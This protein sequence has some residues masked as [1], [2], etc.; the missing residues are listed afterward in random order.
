MGNTGLEQCGFVLSFLIFPIGFFYILSQVIP[1]DNSLG[2]VGLPPVLV[3]SKETVLDA[4]TTAYCLFV[5]VPLL[6]ALC[7][8]LTNPRLDST[9]NLYDEWTREPANTS[10]S[11][12][13]GPPLPKEHVP[14]IC[15]FPV[16]LVNQKMGA[17]VVKTTKNE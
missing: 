8:R 16:A 3:P 12:Q 14:E 17:R 9:S 13:S 15:D 5:A 1:P 4:S 6:Y 7:N 11:K 10:L 2:I